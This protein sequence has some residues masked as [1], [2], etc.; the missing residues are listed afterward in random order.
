MTQQVKERPPVP[1]S[2]FP[3]Y[4]LPPAKDIPI[5]IWIF[6]ESGVGKTEFAAEL[7]IHGPVLYL[8]AEKSLNK[9]RHHPLVKEI[10]PNLDIIN[11]ST[12][13]EIQNAFACA[14]EGKDRY[15]WI[16]IDS[17]TDLNR[18]AKDE[19]L[20][21]S[22]ESDSLSIREW[23]KI[24]I[25]MEKI[26]RYFRDLGTNTMFV[27][28]SKDIKN[29]STGETKAFP[30]IAGNLKEEGAAMVDIMGYMYS[31]DNGNTEEGEETRALQFFN[32][33]RALG[34]DRFDKLKTEILPRTGGCTQILKKLGLL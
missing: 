31:F 19:I 24:S 25:R 23:G 10:A 22:K 9:I 18:C 27:S 12:W 15:K 29:D 7:A 33:P 13:E 1:T 20:S 17:L 5:N 11:V 32:S 6:G 28:L 2:R 34:K 30:Q 8:N 3:V 26:I 16:I 21:S 4:K 14:Y